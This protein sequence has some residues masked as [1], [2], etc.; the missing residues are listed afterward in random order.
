MG[1]SHIDGDKN[2]ENPEFV[3]NDFI[4]VDDNARITMLKSSL[5]QKIDK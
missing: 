5:F 4:V 3:C 1:E 2:K